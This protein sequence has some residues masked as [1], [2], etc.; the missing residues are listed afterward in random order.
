[1][2]KAQILV[3]GRPLE[4][5]QPGVKERCEAAG[6]TKGPWQTH[7]VRTMVKEEKD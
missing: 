2:L 1:M 3:K 7:Q 6:K 4:W 5:H